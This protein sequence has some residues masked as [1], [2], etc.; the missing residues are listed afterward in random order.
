MGQAEEKP[1]AEPG[2]VQHRDALVL[3]EAQRDVDLVDR[4][5]AV[6]KTVEEN[7]GTWL[8][9]AVV[10]SETED[11]HAVIIPRP[12][13]ARWEN[14]RDPTS[15]GRRGSGSASVSSSGCSSW[16]LWCTPCCATAPTSS[17]AGAGSGSVRAPSPWLS[18]SAPSS[19]PGCSGGSPCAVWE[20]TSH[21]PCPPGSSSSASSG[22]TLPARC[23]RW[24]SRS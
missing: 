21:R 16:R 7:T 5:T 3:V 4:G 2:L 12:K 1:V 24:S 18:A 6:A 19:P 20:S 11:A 13:E 15:P 17:T 9:G 22:S 8:A 10:G 23:G 14:P